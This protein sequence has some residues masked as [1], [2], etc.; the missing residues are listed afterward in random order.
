VRLVDLADLRAAGTGAA[1]ALP[2][3]VAAVEAVIEA[4]LARYRRWSVSRGVGAALRRLRADAEQVARQEIAAA[5]AELRPALE[6]A[7]LR[8]AH[9]LA[10]ETTRQLLAAAEDGDAALVTRLATLYAPAVLP[11][12]AGPAPDAPTPPPGAL[13]RVAA[14]GSAVD[15]AD[16]A[17]GLGD[18]FGRR[19][20]LDPQR[21]Q[22]GA[23]E[24][25]P[26][27]RRVH[28]ADE[29]AV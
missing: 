20:A 10:H 1:G 3:A 13:A 18:A 17:A 11:P 29:L 21:V 2:Q 8:T 23:G 4:E 12:S 24:Q 26:Y 25:P 9:R 19:P 15:D 27:Q 28:P 14:V 16:A 7:V 22:L 5:P 6:R